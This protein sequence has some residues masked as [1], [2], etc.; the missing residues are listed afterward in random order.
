MPISSASATQLFAIAGP[1]AKR[2][3]LLRMMRQSPLGHK[4]AFR[5]GT[6]VFP[7][8]STQGGCKGREWVTNGNAIE[9]L[10]G[11]LGPPINGLA[12][13]SAEDARLVPELTNV[14]HSR[15]G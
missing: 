1:A 10:I 9:V 12:R 7:H 3:I 4:K 6:V 5:L 14:P 8:P 11:S 2:V 15:K 13:C